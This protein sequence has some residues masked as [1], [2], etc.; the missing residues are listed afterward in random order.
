MAAP[1]PRRQGKSVI[2]RAIGNLKRENKDLFRS[3]ITVKGP[4]SLKQLKIPLVRVLRRLGLTR[5]GIPPEPVLAIDTSIVAVKAGFDKVG[6]FARVARVRSATFFFAPAQD[7]ALNYASTFAAA[8][9]AEFEPLFVIE[10][11]SPYAATTEGQVDPARPTIGQK[12]VNDH[13]YLKLDRVHRASGVPAEFAAGALVASGAAQ[14][15]VTHDTDG[16]LASPVTII[17]CRRAAR[18]RSRAFAIV[19]RARLFGKLLVAELDKDTMLKTVCFLYG[20][21]EAPLDIVDKFKLNYLTS[22]TSVAHTV[23]TL[24]SAIGHIAD[25]YDL[26]P[27]DDGI[28]GLFKDKV[29]PLDP[30]DTTPSSPRKNSRCHHA[31]ELLKVISRL[32]DPSPLW[33]HTALYLKW[34]APQLA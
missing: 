6:F 30:F 26:T 32:D 31:N 21:L 5:A 33:N 15:L 1:A 29:D 17:L 2:N 4:R 20:L 27:Y 16:Y 25:H 24:S 9:K 12:R 3:I 14:A 13:L 34:M 19:D 11:A 7:L 22:Q 23:F 18:P 8:Y 28:V 10:S